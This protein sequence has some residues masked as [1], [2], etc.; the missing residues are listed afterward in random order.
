LTI[1]C[2]HDGEARAE[3]FRIG[4]QKMRF[5]DGEKNT[6]RIND[7]MSLQGIPAVAHRYQVNGKTPLEWFIDRYRITKD[8]QSGILNDPNAWFKHPQDLVT[9]IKRI[10]HVSVETMRIV[11]ALPKFNLSDVHEP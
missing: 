9:A 3:H 7:H 8:K 5:L 4:H 11:N 10:V 2:A 1:K 6:L